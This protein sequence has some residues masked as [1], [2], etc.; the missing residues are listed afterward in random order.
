MAGQRTGILGG[1]FDPVHS[2]HLAI[3]G[4]VQTEFE[5]DRVIFVPAGSPRLKR[6]EP[7]AS[8]ADRL[9][10]VKIAVAS[11]YAGFEASEVETARSGPTYTVDTSGRV[12]P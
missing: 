8:V 3:A 4:L 7:G 10:M 11:Y 6:Q 2:G 9:E 5:L 12:R 1:T